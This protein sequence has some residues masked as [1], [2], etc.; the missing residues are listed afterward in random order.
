MTIFEDDSERQEIQ[1]AS[2]FKSTK[3]RYLYLGEITST[4]KM[5]VQE[6]VLSLAWGAVSDVSH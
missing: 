3:P 2:F 6:R 1:L 4:P 5:V